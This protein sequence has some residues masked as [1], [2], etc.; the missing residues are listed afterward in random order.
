MIVAA[1][2]CVGSARAP[3]PIIQHL[4]FGFEGANVSCLGKISLYIGPVNDNGI[5]AI[6]DIRAPGDLIFGIRRTSI[7]GDKNL[8][9]CFQPVSAVEPKEK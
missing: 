2:V 1:A 8:W 4:N 5:T 3:T 6:C 7:V 9:F